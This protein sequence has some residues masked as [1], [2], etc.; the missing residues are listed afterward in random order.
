MTELVRY[1]SKERERGWFFLDAK[2]FYNGPNHFLVCSALTIGFH[3]L[4]YLD[5]E[6][7]KKEDVEK[8]VE[9]SLNMARKI[10]FGEIVETDEEIY[11]E[12]FLHVGDFGRLLNP[13]L[14]KASAAIKVLDVYQEM[15]KF[16][17]NQEDK[18]VS[19]E[20][21]RN[22][23]PIK[24]W[25]EYIALLGAFNALEE[26]YEFNEGLFGFIVSQRLKQVQILPDTTTF[27]SAFKGTAKGLFPLAWLEV[28]TAYQWGITAGVCPYCGD[29]FFQN[30][31]RNK[32]TCE[33]HVEMRKK[34]NYLKRENEFRRKCG[35]H[36]I[37]DVD[38]AKREYESRQRK[39]RETKDDVRFRELAKWLEQRYGTYNA[40]GQRINWF[41]IAQ[42]LHSESRKKQ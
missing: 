28:W 10:L 20:W 40:L 22:N 31:N 2:G 34:M 29:I 21:H 3:P 26:R 11:M 8:K 32:K 15:H 13:T 35:L 41:G 36:E 38:Q 39:I 30:K 25:L 18:T 7:E 16:N 33:K 1:L 24:Y 9:R 17:L 12:P 37:N 27:I 42:E 19:W 4:R 23:S 14:L 5:L 6:T